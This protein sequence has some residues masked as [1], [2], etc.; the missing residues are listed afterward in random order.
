MIHLPSAAPIEDS[1]ALLL[2]DSLLHPT[3]TNQA[4]D[5]DGK[6]AGTQ[7]GVGGEDTPRRLIA[8]AGLESESDS[9]A[10]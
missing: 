5:R 3:A 1:H 8:R 4:M 7:R 6:I 2:T 10:S 9:D